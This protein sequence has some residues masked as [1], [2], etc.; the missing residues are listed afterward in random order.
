MAEIVYKAV[1][2][3]DVGFIGINYAEGAKYIAMNSTAQEC[4]VSPL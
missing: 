3:T 2:E 4:R 1:M